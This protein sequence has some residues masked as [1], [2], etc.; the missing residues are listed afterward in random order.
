M[1]EVPNDSAITRR[2]WP[3]RRQWRV[4][5]SAAAIAVAAM[6]VIWLAPRIFGSREPAG[7]PAALPPGTFRPTAAQLKTLTVEAVGTHAFVSEEL[8]EGKIA[9]N[10]DHATAVFTPF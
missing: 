2:A 1:S 5:G 4:V 7:A 8:T 10:A 9:A 6:L 3:P